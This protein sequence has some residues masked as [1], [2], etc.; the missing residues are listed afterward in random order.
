MFDPDVRNFI[1][2]LKMR[3]WSENITIVWRR[4]QCLEDKKDIWEIRNE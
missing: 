3:T 1:E 2:E 4:G